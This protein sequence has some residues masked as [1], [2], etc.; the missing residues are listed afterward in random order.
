MAS[1]LS[2]GSSNA[3][4]KVAGKELAEVLKSLCEDAQVSQFVITTFFE[5][6][7][8]GFHVRF[9]HDPSPDFDPRE[10]YVLT[11]LQKLQM[12]A[13]I[14]KSKNLSRKKFS[15]FKFPKAETSSS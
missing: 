11:E 8:T 10:S 15:S 4:L 5:G 3:T 1:I 6:G 7:E 2:V 12:P 13:L 14:F 9:H